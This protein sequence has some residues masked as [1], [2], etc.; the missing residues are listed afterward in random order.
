MKLKSAGSKEKKEAATKEFKV[1]R[2]GAGKRS[3][4]RSASVGLW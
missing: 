3:C 1:I 4:R 2:V